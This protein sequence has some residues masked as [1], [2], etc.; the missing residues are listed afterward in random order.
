MKKVCD[1]YGPNGVDLYC[2]Q[3]MRHEQEVEKKRQELINKE[4]V[5]FHHDKATPHTFSHLV[6]NIERAGWEGIMHPPCSPD[7]APSDF[8]LFQSLQNSLCGIRL[9]FGFRSGNVFEE[10]DDQ[11]LPVGVS[12]R[13]LRTRRRPISTVRLMLDGR[14][15]AFFK[16]I[17]FEEIE[18]K[19]ARSR[20]FYYDKDPLQPEGRSAS[21]QCDDT[22]AAAALR[23][24]RPSRE[25]RPML[26]GT[27][28]ELALPTAYARYVE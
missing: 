26:T 9:G 1:V 2:Q 16:I 25:R 4:G 24:D 18:C 5:V 10:L 21:R 27:S 22:P 20:I 12:I 14:L 19:P 11:V 7:L 6:A 15:R 28:A 3:L 13:H 23:A 8:H 17:I